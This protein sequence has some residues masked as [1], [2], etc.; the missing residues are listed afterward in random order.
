[1]ASPETSSPLIDPASE[2]RRR[3][4]RRRWRHIRFAER[5]PRFLLLLDRFFYG[6]DEKPGAGSQAL[7][8][9][10]FLRLLG[11]VYLEAFGSIASQI[12]GL[13]GGRGILPASRFMDAVREALGSNGFWRLPTLCWW[14]ASDATLHF[15]S[16]GGVVLS[17]ALIVG[18]V[19]QVCLVLLWVFYLSIVNVGQDFLSFQWDALLL[20]VGFLAIFWAPQTKLFLG[21]RNVVPP[22]RVVR[23]LLLWL[24]FRLMFLSGVVKIRSGD[25]NWTNL[26]AMSFHYETQPL[27]TWTS[28]YVAHEPM[29]M[30]RGET[31]ATF[32]IELFVPLLYFMPRRLRLFG[33]L[34][35]ILLQISIATTGNYGFFN[36]LTIVLC[37]PLLDDAAWPNVLRKRFVSAESATRPRP[38]WRE[39]A[40]APLAGAIIVASIIHGIHRAHFHPTLPKPAYK[41]EELVGNLRVT[42]AYGLFE[43]MTT[44]RPEIVIEGSDDGVTW[45]SYRFRWKP[46]DDLTRR[47]RFATP[48]MPRLDWQLW[49]AAMGR[50]ENSPWT[51]NLMQRILESSPPVM[52][53]LRDNPFPNAPPRYVRAKLYMYHFTTSPERAQS[54]AW[55]KRE[56][57]GEFCPP[58]SLDD[59]RSLNRL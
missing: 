11:V 34:L 46:D 5:Y 35:T 6:N 55:W 9:A 48:H 8:R 45:K 51:I 1:V 24:L 39:L 7:T 31:L 41:L 49:F 43:V 36:L 26:T 40:L 28:W 38:A 37:I 27:P 25:P 12:A 32:V 58:V 52:S 15:L 44:K 2:L 18:V 47:P 16:I 33:C 4:T 23:F 20:E 59:L 54:G 50:V 29:W 17:L 30:H 57:L 3:W 10:I 19:P 21:V 13:V 42:S 53:L 22:S 14:N 56:E